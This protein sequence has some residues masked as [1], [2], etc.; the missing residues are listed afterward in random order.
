MRDGLLD[1]GELAVV[2]EAVEGGGV[3]AG[4][5]EL[6]DV[7]VHALG[8]RAV[9]VVVEVVLEVEVARLLLVLRVVAPLRRQLLVDVLA[10]DRL[11]ELDD[12]L[13]DVLHVLLRPLLRDFGPDL[14]QR[15]QVNG[16]HRLVLP[17]LQ[18][19]PQQFHVVFAQRLHVFGHNRLVHHQLVQQTVQG[20]QVAQC[21][22]EGASAHV[23]VQVDLLQV[24]RDFLGVFGVVGLRAAW[25]G[26]LLLVEFDVA[27]DASFGTGLGAEVALGAWG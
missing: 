18:E 16:R 8:D 26:L 20:L 21:R 7:D 11:Q 5:E 9:V 13:E 22:F 25:L 19:Q 12:L 2:H 17:F 14:V 3:L 10:V 1:Q 24:D 4:V 27:A 23:L 15:L 6:L